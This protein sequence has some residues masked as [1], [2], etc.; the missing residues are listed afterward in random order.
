VEDPIIIL[1]M[2]VFN[3]VLHLL[4]FVQM[5]VVGVR[6]VIVFRMIFVVLVVPL[7]LFIL[8]SLHIVIEVHI[9]Y[10]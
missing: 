5:S 4:W 2:H 6:I 10:R 9:V 3:V 7:C 8:M 1:V